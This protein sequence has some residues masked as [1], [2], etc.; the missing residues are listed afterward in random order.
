[1]SNK[2]TETPDQ[3]KRRNQN[4]PTPDATREPFSTPGTKAEID[5]AGKGMV[6]QAHPPVGP[7]IER[8]EAESRDE[9]GDPGI[10]LPH[11]RD[12][13]PHMTAAQPDPQIEQAAKDISNGLKD[14][15]KA[16]ETDAAYKKFR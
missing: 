8:S 15:S 5:S 12:Q 2:I 9:A 16:A 6:T 4:A 1:M 7:A 14:T 10:G 13:S 11:E 3:P